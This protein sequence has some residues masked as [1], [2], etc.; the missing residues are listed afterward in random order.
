MAGATVQYT[1]AGAFGAAF[2]FKKCSGKGA[3]S[4]RAASPSALA[5]AL[6]H[7]NGGTQCRDV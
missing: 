1:G 3:Q 6:A 2:K 4:P 5:L 7:I